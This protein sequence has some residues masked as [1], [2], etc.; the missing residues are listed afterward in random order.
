MVQNEK[1]DIELETDVGKE[2][3]LQFIRKKNIEY[4]T[5]DEERIL[6]RMRFIAREFSFKDFSELLKHLKQNPEDC[7]SAL[8]WLQ[9]G[10]VYNERIDHYYPLVKRKKT[11]SEYAQ[12]VKKKKKSSDKT[13]RKR[14]LNSLLKDLPVTFGDPVDPDNLIKLLEVL[15]R[16]KVNYKAYKTN[17]LL[18][19]IHH[20]MR[21][22]DLDSYKSYSELVDHDPDE[23]VLLLK[24][25]SINVTRFFRNKD[26]YKALDKNI[27]PQIFKEING[28]INIW[29]AG[30]AVG[31]EPYSIAMLIDSKYNTKDKR[32]V[33]I[34][35]TDIS[36]DFLKKA[37]EGM[38]D[39]D[40]LK[41]TSPD[42]LHAYFQKK[43]EKYLI[44]QKLKMYIQFKTHDLR[45]P[46]PVHNLDLILCRNV[47]IYFS[48]EESIK[49]FERMHK[50]L[51]PKGF[52]VLGKCEM[53]RG[54]V[55]DEFEVVDARNRIYQK[56]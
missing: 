20:R 39:A 9:R 46:A 16:K 43:R 36:L 10:K 23:L 44:S 26:M 11:I 29:S 24:S 1:F 42:K 32:R 37:K 15:D 34:I 47:L 38:F 45:T 7:E 18:R 40:L 25:F 21:R 53:M 22:N 48:Q 14:K 12:M 27:L 55:R 19:R 31:A 6:R 54:K 50:A 41:E 35:A 2:E 3:I 49:L 8:D 51:K 30:C 13:K 4:K 17:Y 52:L 28:S 5:E 33:N 56:K